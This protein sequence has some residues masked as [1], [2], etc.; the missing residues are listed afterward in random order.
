MI[1]LPIR[2]LALVA[3]PVCALLAV[4]CSGSNPQLS[5]VFKAPPW[6]GPE[7]YTYTL[8]DQGNNQTGTCVLNTKP[9]FPPGETTLEYL[10]NDP[11]GD[12][13]DR[14]VVANSQTLVPLSSSRTIF[15]KSA[16]TRTVVATEYSGTKVQLK[17][18]DNGTIHTVSRDLP[19]PTNESPDPGYYSDEAIFWVVRGI[20]LQKGYQGA[21]VDVNASASG[22]QTFTA[23]IKVETA[24][25]VK[26]PAGTFQAWRVRLE[27]DSIT[28][29]FW[30]NEAAPHQVIQ[31]QIEA[32]KFQLASLK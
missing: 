27:T 2:H 22:G 14:T 13:D 28:Q 9:G 20:P 18:N 30:V 8:V 3:L 19:K 6:A 31:A 26:V 10:C 16:N 23:T 17:F 15:N 12:R 24:E 11:K 1:R 21:Y 29:Y 32:T 4:A 7:T 5:H 25:Q